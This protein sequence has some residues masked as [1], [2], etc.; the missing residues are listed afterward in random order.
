MIGRLCELYFIPHISRAVRIHN[1][2]HIDGPWL[3]APAKTNMF[4]F[5]KGTETVM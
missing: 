1:R 2:H 3:L 5:H 4:G